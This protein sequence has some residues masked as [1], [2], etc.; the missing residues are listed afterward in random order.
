MKS[1]R[2][3]LLAAALWLSSP[4]VS[5][6][7]AGD[8]TAPS[9]AFPKDAPYQAAV[10]KV[11]MDK[12]FKFL[13]GSFINADTTLEYTG[14]AASLN[15]FLAHLAAC[16]GIEVHVTFSDAGDLS[17][18]ADA[19]WTL[20]HNAWGAGSEFYVIVNKQLIA[21]STVI[22]PKATQKDSTQKKEN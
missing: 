10:M 2:F 9:L 13:R 6:S 11:I 5:F 12:N 19:A 20:R 8:L 7:A 3:P 21:E 16:A 18:D 4:E 14:N 15:T 1:F 22:V 17:N